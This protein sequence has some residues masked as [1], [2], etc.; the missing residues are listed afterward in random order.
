M[1]ISMT[2]ATLGIVPPPPVISSATTAKGTEGT[3]F[4]YQI[5]ASHSPIRYG[6]TGLPAG[7]SLDSATGM[8]SG[9]PTASGTSTVTLSATNSGGTGTAT[10]KLTIHHLGF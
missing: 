2:G 4:R 8:I 5:T 3:G 9:T 7:L 6:A 10:M 1:S